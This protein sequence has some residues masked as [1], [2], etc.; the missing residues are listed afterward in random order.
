MEWD[1]FRENLYLNVGSIRKTTMHTGEVY[2]PS[3]W[4]EGSGVLL[5]ISE[6]DLEITTVGL[7]SGKKQARGYYQ[8]N[9]KA[10]QNHAV[11]KL[12]NE[13]EVEMEQL[14]VG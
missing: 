7:Y 6:S 8:F 5:R 10:G 3:M 4:T 9:V 11:Y 1:E 12:Q 14:S 2:V 13:V